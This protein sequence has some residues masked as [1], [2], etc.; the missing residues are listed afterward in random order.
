MH[1][2][3]QSQLYKLVECLLLGISCTISSVSMS[4]NQNVEAF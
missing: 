4:V 1:F 2:L 3:L